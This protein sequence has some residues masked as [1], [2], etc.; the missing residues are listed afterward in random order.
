MS[1]LQALVWRTEKRRV[2]DLL[3]Y[4]KNPRK[5]SEKQMEDLKESLK[6]FNLAELPA[7]NLDG[8]ICA[9]HQRIKALQLLG[10]G[11]ELIEVRTPNRK[12]TPSE[13]K[14][15]LLTSNRSGGS[16]DWEILASDF[17]IDTLLTSGFDSTDLTNIFD[18]S[19]EVTDDNFDEEKELEK[20]K[21]T[22]IKTG[23]IFQIGR[24][25]LIC[26]SSLDPEVVKKLMDGKQ[27]DMVNDDPPFN[28]GL[29][30]DKGVGN[31]AK[32]GGT[33]NDS[34]SE[35]E[36]RTFLKTLIQNALKVSKKD[37]H[38]MFWC[39]ER[40]VYLLQEIYKELG[41]DSK[42]LCIWIKD[43]ASPTPNVAFNKVTE[44]CVYG[45]VGSPY[46]SD[47]VKNLNEVLNKEATTGNRL[48][49]D[50]LDMLN[51]WLV[52]RLPSQDYQH[53]TQKPPT[54][55]EKALRR[56]ARPNDIVLDLT[57][58]SGSILSACEQ[59]KRT[60]YLC[61]LEPI[62]CQLIINRFKQLSPHEKITKLN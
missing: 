57:A 25:R 46:L 19:L 12:L 58:G 10:R 2:N 44:Y 59:L 14:Q 23:D 26:G 35:S 13:F 52:K 27:A 50:I 31:K 43:N 11:E 62:F 15:Y 24:H 8:K 45:T 39:D 41:I 22:D 34:K 3:P 49:D 7:I 47:K 56:C 18:D 30:Y 32:Y 60:A 51:I 48:S 53:P 38:I 5:I 54:L 42:R 61:E 16:W 37:A 6:K 4:E 55:H 21:E 29:S 28:I 40:Y 36:Y 17:D 33:T 9:G 20:I 1:K